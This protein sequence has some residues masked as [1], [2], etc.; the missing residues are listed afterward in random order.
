MRLL[1]FACIILVGAA[2]VDAVTYQFI[3]LTPTGFTNT[4]ASGTGGSQQ[5]GQG[6]KTLAGNVHSLLWNG[7]AGSVVDLHPATLTQSQAY[8]TSGSVQVGSGRGAL[9]PAINITH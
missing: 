9:P 3:D 2:S 1:A 5:V 6:F 4:I 8:A 7:S